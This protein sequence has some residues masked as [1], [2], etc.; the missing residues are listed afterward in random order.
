MTAQDR[1]LSLRRL[2]A[3]EQRQVSRA[4]RDLGPLWT[5][6]DETVAAYSRIADAIESVREASREGDFTARVLGG[7][8]FLRQAGH[9]CQLDALSIARRHWAQAA[10]NRR[11][12]FDAVAFA[13]L[14]WQGPAL[15]TSWLN[16]T[17]HWETYRAD[18]KPSRIK[19]ALHEM[20]PAPSRDKPSILWAA[21]D[22]MSGIVHP[23][24]TGTVHTVTRMASS[25]TLDRVGPF[26][27]MTYVRARMLPALRAEW[28]LDFSHCHLLLLEAFTRRAFARKE[29][30]VARREATA[31]LVSLRERV[32][33]DRRHAAKHGRALDAFREQCRRKTHERTSAG[34]S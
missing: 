2:A 15:L 12:A 10:A 3:A 8:H 11:R 17:D 9:A 34:P 5:T 33:G 30:T 31:T 13:W 24:T 18:F 21:Y 14:V 20:S 22:R 19:A 23:S 28:F 25:R 27:G 4:I 6:A 26:D 7:N 29:W 16:A 1:T 32:R